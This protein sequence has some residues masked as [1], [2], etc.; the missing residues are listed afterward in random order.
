MAYCINCGTELV[1]GAKFCFECGTPVNNTAHDSGRKTFF[2]G[3]LHKC[4]QCGEILNAFV[5][6][7]PVCGYELRGI[8]K[9]SSVNDLALKLE[10]TTSLQQKHELISNFYIPNTREDIYEF[11]ILAYS[12][13]SAGDEAIDAWLAKLE[14]AYLKAK[15]AFGESR[16]LAQ[17]TLSYKKIIKD[18]KYSKISRIVKSKLA[19]SIA[20]IILGII[21]VAWGDEIAPCMLA[22]ILVFGGFPVI[23]LG[24]IMLVIPKKKK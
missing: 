18:Y 20:I 13:I 3:E 8:R 9:T 4:P 22:N 11:F 14:Q 24:V 12:N 21:M 23:A 16:E 10:E 6:N 5:M 7:C 1:D 17:I 2:D 15:I 19:K